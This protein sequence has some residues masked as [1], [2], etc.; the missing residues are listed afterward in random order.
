MREWFSDVLDKDESISGSYKP[1][2]FKFF[3]MA[4]LTYCVVG[5]TIVLFATL[6]VIFPTDKE[7]APTL[8]YRFIPSAVFFGRTYRKLL[9]RRGMVQK[10][11]L[12][13]YK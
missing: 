8:W 3:F 6:A 12:L 13:L 11:G 2:K 4:I 1:E 10:C 9:F 5:L 7:E